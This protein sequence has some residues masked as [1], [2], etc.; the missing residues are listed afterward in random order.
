MD[1]LGG[2][3]G[4]S[5]KVTALYRLENWALKQER[6]RDI[7]SCSTKVLLGSVPAKPEQRAKCCWMNVWPL[8][9]GPGSL[10]PTGRSSHKMGNSWGGDSSLDF[11]V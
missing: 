9:V 11:E 1:F 10:L 4:A 3:P 5:W 2:S 7:N 6:S 8:G